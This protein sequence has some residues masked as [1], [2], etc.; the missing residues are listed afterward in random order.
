MAPSLRSLV[1]LLFGPLLVYALYLL[2]GIPVALFYGRTVSPQ[3]FPVML[4]A[5]GVFVGLYYG[6][7]RFV[8]VLPIPRPPTR[9]SFPDGTA[10]FKIPFLSETGEN[11]D[12]ETVR[13]WMRYRTGNNAVLFLLT[14]LL[15]VLV[16]IPLYPYFESRGETLD[17]AGPF[18]VIMLAAVI[19]WQWISLRLEQQYTSIYPESHSRPLDTP[20]SKNK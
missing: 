2:I 7:Y 13:A 18:W 1:V 3:P 11:E 16:T 12:F 20:E 15:V 10:P 14:P 9:I 8:G 6:V 4:F 19:T 17:P 5:I